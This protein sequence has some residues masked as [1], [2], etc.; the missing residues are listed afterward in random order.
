MISFNTYVVLHSVNALSD[1]EK[2]STYNI[3]PNHSPLLHGSR[4]TQRGWGKNY[5]NLQTLAHTHTH[6]QTHTHTNHS[7]LFN[8]LSRFLITGTNRRHIRP[9]VIEDHPHR[10]T[11]D[12]F[13]TSQDPLA[14]KRDLPVSFFSARCMNAEFEAEFRHWIAVHPASHSI[15]SCKGTMTSIEG[16]NG[17]EGSNGRITIRYYFCYR[18]GTHL[19]HPL[20]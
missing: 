8:P 13:G 7:T 15:K 19:L 12:R 3:Q 20:G 17:G 2:N 9:C 6:T 4:H 11:S 10:D 5:L 18:T 16:F 14:F 1:D